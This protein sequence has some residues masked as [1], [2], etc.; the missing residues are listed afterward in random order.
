M[1]EEIKK[2]LLTAVNQ[3]YIATLDDD[4]FDFANITITKMLMHHQTTYDLITHAKLECNCASISTG[5][6]ST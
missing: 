2:Q 5:V 4:V 3:L 6:D 1:H